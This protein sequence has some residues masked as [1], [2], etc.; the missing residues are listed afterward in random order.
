MWLPGRGA[1]GCGKVFKGLK[2]RVDNVAVKVIRLQGYVGGDYRSAIAQFKQ[3]ID[4]I[5]LWCYIT[6]NEKIQKGHKRIVE[7]VQETSS[8]TGVRN[9]AIA[10]LHEQ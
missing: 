1:R 7:K 2:D 10:V 4:T 5:G 8:D 3:E 6:S 9:R